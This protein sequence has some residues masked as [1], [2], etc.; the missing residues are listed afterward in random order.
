MPFELPIEDGIVPPSNGLAVSNLVKRKRRQTN[1]HTLTYIPVSE[2]VL[3]EFGKALP[4]SE[5][6]SA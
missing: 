5:L 2:V 6:N 1:E 4:P 3:S